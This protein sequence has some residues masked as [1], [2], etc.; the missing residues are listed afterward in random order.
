MMETNTAIKYSF[1]TLA[2]CLFGSIRSGLE[3]TN[4]KAEVSHPL[5]FVEVKQTNRKWSGCF[6]SEP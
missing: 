3:Q 4:P 1:V 6:T 5:S 2:G